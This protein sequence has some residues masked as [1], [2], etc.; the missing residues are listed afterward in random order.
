MTPQE[1][2]KELVD[3]FEPFCYS[4]PRIQVTVYDCAKHCVLISVDEIIN[5]CA[6]GLSE[7]NYWEQVK[8]EINNL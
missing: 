6:Q 3:K 2:A 1:K 7:T 8:H 4:D 5:L